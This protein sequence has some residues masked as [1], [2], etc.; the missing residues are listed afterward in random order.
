MEPK[1]AKGSKFSKVAELMRKKS[2]AGNSKKR[3]P[4]V[5]NDPQVTEL[6]PTLETPHNKHTPTSPPT[7]LSRKRPRE[8]SILVPPPL[9][10]A[11]EPLD[12]RSYFMSR[13]GANCSLQCDATSHE[14]AR[15]C[16]FPADARFFECMDDLA[17]K[18]IINQCLFQALNA[19]NINFGRITK[20]KG[21][22]TEMEVQK[23]QMEDALKGIENSM[24]E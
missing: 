12:I 8:S 1:K 11:G 3:V 10:R 4:S 2:D 19:N 6:G 22:Y 21:A 15:H 20:S 14:M 7:E 9:L 13:Y 5:T 16:L 24:R 23:I 18:D 17:R